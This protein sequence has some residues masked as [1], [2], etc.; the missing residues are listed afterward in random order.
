MSLQLT[1]QA[2]DRKV[3]NV[4]KEKSN[5]SEV[6]KMLHQIMN[7]RSYVDAQSSIDDMILVFG[8]EL[9]NEENEK[10]ANILFS[11]INNQNS[12]KEEVLNRKLSIALMKF[13]HF[14]EKEDTAEARSELSL[15]KDLIKRLPENERLEY[16][17][18]LKVYDMMLG[19]RE[20]ENTKA[21]EEYT[22]MLIEAMEESIDEDDDDVTET[23]GADIVGSKTRDRILAEKRKN[24]PK[25]K[26]TPKVKSDE[27][28]Q[29]SQGM[30][31][32]EYGMKMGRLANAI[33][34]K[35]SLSDFKSKMQSDVNKAHVYMID[36][37][38]EVV[39]VM[40]RLTYNS[41]NQSMKTILSAQS[42]FVE[43]T[44]ENYDKNNK[45]SQSLFN[46]IL[47][48]SDIRNKHKLELSKAVKKSK[49]KE[50]NYWKEKCV[51]FEMPNIDMEDMSSMLSFFER[52][53]SCVETEK[54]IYKANKLEPIKYHNYKSIANSLK[55]NEAVIM[56]IRSMSDNE[57]SYK[58]LVAKNKLASPAWV[59]IGNDINIETTGFKKHE[60]SLEVMNDPSSF[61]IYFEELANVLGEN[62]SDVAVINDGVFHKINLGSLYH[63]GKNKYL[64]EL[65]SFTVARDVNFFNYE[66][67][68]LE[69]ND[70]ITLCGASDFQEVSKNT[71][72]KGTTFKDLPQVVDELNE[73]NALLSKN[74]NSSVLLDNDFTL[75]S[76]E[77]QDN[78]DVLHVST[79]GYY[80][81]RYYFTSDDP[82]EKNIQ[83]TEV[84]DKPINLSKIE[85]EE[86]VG[87]SFYANLAKVN[88]MLQSGLILGGGEYINANT[89]E[90]I[91]L[92]NTK[93]VVLSACHSGRGALL[94]GQ[95]TFGVK[96]SILMSGAEYIL[97]STHEVGDYETLEFM[98][99]FYS[100]L[101]SGESISQSYAIAVN[102]IRNDHP[103]IAP[104]LP[105]IW[106]AFIL[107][108]GYKD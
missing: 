18:S 101:T 64:S 71:Q 14:L 8:M 42:F 47:N 82:N 40:N 3:I 7:S 59:S 43:F 63:A 68:S 15:L 107:E 74:Y 28:A 41:V 80:L 76:F 60:S 54:T 94:S 72:L 4:I 51:E 67:L 102:Y 49:T 39:K 6:A 45:L 52:S 29:I 35:V 13:S 87:A 5:N 86:G 91:E 55:K 75:N 25:K 33:E 84:D 12:N 21:N 26:K 44:N 99:S 93:L 37:T 103:V 89:I 1:G 9:L 70:H 81:P 78:L 50:T 24:N 16:E 30:A 108:R 23:R 34:N 38:N 92:A 77:S 10:E 100:S 32:M 95:G 27:D 20:P 85:S 73:I 2:I 11:H 62:I 31:M 97:S 98:K 48:L 17:E 19:I 90:R 105:Y 56:I 22:K 46:F 88:P 104:S 58:A 65:Y 66:D 106:G 96:N 36:Y 69:K 57:P 53:D 83:I 79:H 61:N